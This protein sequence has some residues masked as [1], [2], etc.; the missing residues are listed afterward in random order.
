MSG[1]TQSGDERTLLLAF[2]DEQR[3]IVRR[4]CSGLGA[5][6][7]DTPL[8]PSDM[9]LGGLL[10][11]LAYVESWWTTGVLLGRDQGEPWD[12]VDW[13]ADGDWDWHSARDDS[14]EQ[15]WELY[16]R[17]VA[18]ADEVIAGAALDDPSAR[19]NART[20]ERP[21]LRWILLHLIEE[22][23]RHA[24]HADLI[25]ESIDGQTDA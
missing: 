20:G 23:A 25:R 24:G 6:Q 4:K 13:S 8:P 22:Y 18:R 7:L 14:P 11:H 5:E 19:A 17:E 12:S 2:L 1:P 10:K 9:T 16:E 21:S 15:L 3:A